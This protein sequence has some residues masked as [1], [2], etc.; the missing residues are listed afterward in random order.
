[1]IA[2]AAVRMAVKNLVV[3]GSLRDHVDYDQERYVAAVREELLD[4]AIEKSDDAE[5]L[6][7]TITMAK[8]KSGRATNQADYR[9]IDAQLLGRRKEVAHAL[10]ERLRELSDDPEFTEDLARRAHGAAWD[11]VA[12]ALEE[13]LTKSRIVEDANYA[14][15]RGE[16]LLEMLGDL[17]DLEAAQS[18]GESSP[19]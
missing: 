7:A 11:E 2:S 19:S 15:H 6:S 17:A 10:S 4:L 1:M 18:R 5:R 3:L 12:T 9:S 16:R 14:K 13:R 8:S